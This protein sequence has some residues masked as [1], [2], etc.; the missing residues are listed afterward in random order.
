MGVDA[1]RGELL[2][3]EWSVILKQR[4]GIDAGVDC[5]KFI[6]SRSEFE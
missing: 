5:G 1:Q 2:T 4:V 6:L 3:E